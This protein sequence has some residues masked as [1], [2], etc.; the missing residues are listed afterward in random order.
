MVFSLKNL[1]LQYFQK[2]NYKINNEL[3]KRKNINEKTFYDGS[4]LINII[5]YHIDNINDKE[6]YYDNMCKKL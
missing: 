3:I 5:M 2:K 4:I 1:I 6:V